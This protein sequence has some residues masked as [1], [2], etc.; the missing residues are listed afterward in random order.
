[1]SRSFAKY[2]AKPAFG[3][4][5]E[6]LD[7]SDYIKIK[8]TKYSFC[9]PNICHPN[10]N[11]YSESNYLL[12]KQANTLAFYPCKNVLDSSELY[13]N[14]YTELDLSNNVVSVI[15]DLNG[16]LNSVEID[17]TL[18]PY[19]TYEIDPSGNLFGNTVCG[20]DNFRNYVLY[21]PSYSTTNPGK[22]V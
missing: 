18:T 12:L 17:P 21:N 15:T 16:S 7:A 11:V 13:S 2:P 6:P 14:L 1:M 5:N 3:H 9:S 8:K 10:K 19:L 4:I 22:F 20:I